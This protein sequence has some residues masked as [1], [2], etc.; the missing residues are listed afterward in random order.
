MRFFS[1]SFLFKRTLLYLRSLFEDLSNYRFQSSSVV[2]DHRNVQQHSPDASQP[3]AHDY[4]NYTPNQTRQDD[5]PPYEDLSIQL[6]H[7]QHGP[8]AGQYDS[9]N[10]ETTQGK[11]PLYNVISN[12]N[13]PVYVNVT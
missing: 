10:P 5:E 4:V 2:C 6:G 11:Q 7:T 1:A 3:A 12:K 9:L 8:D 13:A